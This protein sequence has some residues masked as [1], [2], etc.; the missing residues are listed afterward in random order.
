MSK[1]WVRCNSL[2]CRRLSAG[3]AALRFDDFNKIHCGYRAEY[4]ETSTKCDNLQESELHCIKAGREAE[5]ERENGGRNVQAIFGFGHRQRNRRFGCS[6]NSDRAGERGRRKLSGCRTRP[7]IG[8]PLYVGASGVSWHSV[9]SYASSARS[10][11]LSSCGRPAVWGHAP[12]HPS[13]SLDIALILFLRVNHQHGGPATSATG[14]PI[15][16]KITAPM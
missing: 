9:T 1:R 5:P 4:L 12:T 6:D 7:A 10:H 14:E 11:L 16:S 2:F 3:K 8:Q 15:A 13:L